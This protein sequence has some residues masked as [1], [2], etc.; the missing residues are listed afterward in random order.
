M[1]SAF[2]TAPASPGAA[3]T[4]APRLT[5]RRSFDSSLP[6]T[7]PT[8]II[9][10]PAAIVSL[11]VSPPAFPITTCAAAMRA[12][13]SRSKPSTR[14]FTPTSA[15]VF[16]TRSSAPLAL[17][18]TTVS[19]TSGIPWNERMM[20]RIG[21]TPKLPLVTSTRSASPGSG[22]TTSGTDSK[23]G[24]TGIP[25]SFILSYGTP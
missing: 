20:A 7:V 4:P 19:S 21:P 10:R 14:A 1:R 18:H 25:V 2:A 11:T 3:A 16:V 15:A 24:R 22:A 6:G 9:A 13:M 23:A 12:A 17:P 8:R 5:T